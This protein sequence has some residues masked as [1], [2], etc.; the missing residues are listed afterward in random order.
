MDCISKRV[1]EHSSLKV[2]VNEVVIMQWISS[3]SKE[4][5]IPIMLYLSQNSYYCVL[6]SAFILNTC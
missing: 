5:T 2:Y 4:K 1:K 3:E 6:Y